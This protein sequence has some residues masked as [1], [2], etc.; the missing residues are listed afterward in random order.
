[1]EA[2][3]KQEKVD[4][5]EA[6]VI[7]MID[8]DKDK[9]A[10]LK[11]GKGVNSKPVK[12]FKQRL[13]GKEGRIRQNLMGKRV[14]FSARSV[15]SPDQNLALDELGVPLSIAEQ[16]T[17]PEI[18][19][20]HNVAKIVQLMKDGKVKYY[21]PMGKHKPTFQWMPTG[22]DEDIQRILEAGVVVER[23]LENGDYVLFNRQPTLHRMSM[24]GHRV[25]I[26]PYSTFRLNLS[27]CTPYNADFDGD[28]MNMH[29]PQ[30]YET[31]AELKHITHVPRQIINP[32]DN[33]PIMGIVQDSLLGTFPRLSRRYQ[34]VLEE[35]HLFDQGAG[36]EHDH[37]H[38]G[39]LGRNS[40]AR[41]HFP[42]APVDWQ[43][44]H[45]SHHPRGHQPGHQP[46]GDQPHQARKRHRF[47]LQFEGQR[48]EDQKGRAGFRRHGKGPGRQ[49]AVKFDS[50]VVAGQGG[51]GHVPVYDPG[52]VF[53]HQLLGFPRV[54]D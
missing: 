47:A 16:M 19:T 31:R 32:K 28:E 21:R 12:S 10:P 20:K 52:A 42:Q 13:Q 6:T 27:V 15:I 40:H 11:V 38:R 39:L 25:R 44:D 54:H 17:I 43:A 5:L 7:R 48:R 14:D 22:R 35:G 24:M 49:R 36:H 37:V 26:L 2:N 9:I 50:C 29:V 33:K 18:V 1:L 4:Q 51:Q 45:E 41:Y 30:N 34:S 23:C 8:N 46:G 53:G 3:S